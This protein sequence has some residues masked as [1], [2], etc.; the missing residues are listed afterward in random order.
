M[1]YQINHGNRFVDNV[2]P[3]PILVTHWKHQRKRVTDVLEI[4]P[5]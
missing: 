3:D 2:H 4:A 5:V 1:L